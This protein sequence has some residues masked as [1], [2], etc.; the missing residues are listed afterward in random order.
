MKTFAQLKRMT[1]TSSLIASF[2]VKRRKEQRIEADGE[3]ERRE[4][5][6]YGLARGHF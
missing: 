1:W 3:E 5:N 4:R 6:G 2:Y